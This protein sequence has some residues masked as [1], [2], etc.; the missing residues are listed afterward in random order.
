MITNAIAYAKFFSRSHDA[1]IRVYDQ[2]GN[3]I[4]TLEHE[5]DFKAWSSVTTLHPPR[6]GELPIRVQETQSAFRQHERKTAFR[7]RDVR[8]QL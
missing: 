5:G 6:T 1:V 4:K 2:A 7:R 8:L 3:V